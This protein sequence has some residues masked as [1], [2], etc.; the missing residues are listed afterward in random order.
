MLFEGRNLHKKF[1]PVSMQYGGQMAKEYQFFWLLLWNLKTLEC[2]QGIDEL[3]LIL[4]TISKRILLK[5]ALTDTPW[6]HLSFINTIKS[7]TLPKR[8]IQCE[9][10]YSSTEFNIKLDQIHINN[11]FSFFYFYKEVSELSWVL[12]KDE[13]RI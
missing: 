1:S 3:S 2:Q 9:A 4:P 10:L 8:H 13:K 11:N 12:A 5:K 7:A 6:H